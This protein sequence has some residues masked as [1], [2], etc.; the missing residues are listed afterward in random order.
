MDWFEKLTGFRETDYASTQQKLEVVGNQLHSK[1]NGKSYGIGTLE[2]ASLKDLR[3]R[4]HAGLGLPGPLKVSLIRGDVR[5][6]HSAAENSGALFQVASQFNLLEMTSPDIT[7]EHGVT[8]YEDDGTQGPAC[9]MAAGAATLYRNYFC[10]VDGQVGQTRSHQL[11]GLAGMG[12]ALSTELG[13]T[14]QTLWSMRNGYA[15]CTAE[16]LDAISSYLESCQPDATDRLRG[17][18]RIGVHGDVQVTDHIGAPALH[19]SQAFCS[20]LPVAYASSRISFSQ[21]AAFATLIL[22][23]AYEATLWAAVL[24][25][26]RTGSNIVFL[27]FLGGGVFGNDAAWITSAMRRAFQLASGFGLDVR[28]VSYGKP[29]P[30]TLKM[31]DDFAS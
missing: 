3:A 4:V 31:V 20:A 28:L 7:P 2:L 11:N 17:L 9:A 10:K 29:F 24:N 19:V 8:R 22:E 18:L 25:A 12:L 13:V 14:L 1:I 30:E 21:W 27:T 16:G 26:Q 23:A 6:M 5:A 15:M